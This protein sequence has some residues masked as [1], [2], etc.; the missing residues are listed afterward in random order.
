[1]DKMLSL[2]MDGKHA[3]LR[4]L[5]VDATIAMSESLATELNA[6]ALEGNP[7]IEYC[8]VHI[9]KAN[10]IT[11]DVK[12]PLWPWPL[13]VKL[14]L[15]SSVDL[16]HSPTVRAFLENHMLLGKLGSLLHALPGGIQLYQDQ[17]SIDLES[18]LPLHE[19]KKLLSLV[20]AIEIRT[21]EGNLFFDIKIER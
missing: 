11:L 21:E 17:V 4:G 19:Q 16:T 7:Q 8:R 10:R 6:I 1:M 12:S 20:K 5:T 13:N 2:F 18:F 3:E 14:K 9:H 15:F